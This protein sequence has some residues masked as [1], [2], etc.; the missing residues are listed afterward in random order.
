MSS[1]RFHSVASRLIILC[2]TFSILTM[3]QVSANQGE[4]P[5]MPV[6]VL[7]VAKSNVPYIKNY[8]VRL[9]ALKT[10]EVHARVTGVIEQQFYTEGQRVEK[11]QKLYQIDSRRYIAKLNQAK[12]NVVSM[13][14]QIAQAKR[15]YKRLLDLSKR[16]SVSQQQ[17]DEAL[18]TV[19]SL[20]AQLQA[21]EAA[22][23]SAQ[24]EVDDTV[25]LAEISGIIGERQQ[26]VGDFVDPISGKT[27]MN[28]II[29]IDQLYG[30]FTLSDIDRQSL[31]SMQADGLL[32]LTDSPKVSLLDNQG[33]SIQIGT[34]DF[35]DMKVDV[36]TANQMLRARFDNEQKQLLP[37]QLMRV[38][39]EHGQW[40]NVMPVPQKAIMQMGPQAL[41][42]VAAEGK[43]QMRPV[44]LAGR[45]QDQ[46]LI[47]GG[48]TSGDQV[49]TGNL[50][51]LRPNSAVQVLPAEANAQ[52]AQ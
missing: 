11:G 4:R 12:A 46:W 44:T 10:V 33:K 48:L 22:V 14:A 24:I 27:L 34:L 37:G 30:T 32:Q 35:K 1:L 50:I 39:V 49:I 26:D 18:A 20:E 36:A 6:Q 43:A 47:S 5:P 42:Y 16:Q 31:N 51:K 21:A 25:V 8:P 13:E 52:N 41:V 40:T 28:Q 29:Q 17:V 15:S 19:E 45:Y 38:S 23:V 9:S 2:F 3:P 7:Q